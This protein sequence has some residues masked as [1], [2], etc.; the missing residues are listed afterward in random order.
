[1]LDSRNY[2]RSGIFS[3]KITKDESESEDYKEEDS[4]ENPFS[5]VDEHWAKDYIKG[6]TEKNLINGYPDGTFKPD[7][8]VTREEFASLL[9]RALQLEKY[10]DTTFEDVVDR[11]STE[12]ISTA[13]YY[14]I[15]KG[16]DEN[17][18]GPEDFITR[19]QMAVM[20]ARALDLEENSGE[21][22]LN[23]IQN[24]SNWARNAIIS[25]VN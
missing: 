25:V 21:V 20:V 3:L 19:E 17:K 1:M 5:D 14:E 24:A 18:F 9:V 15:I 8:N 22:D 2:Y 16:Y 13:A 6:T 4:L 11:W 10:S 12:D 23:D 7:N